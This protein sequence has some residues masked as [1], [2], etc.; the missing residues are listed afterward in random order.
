MS[1]V[2]LLASILAISSSPNLSSPWPFI[3]IR[4][5]D[6]SHA[7]EK[8]DEIIGVNA[9]HPGSAD[10]YWLCYCGGHPIDKTARRFAKHASACEKM[11]KAGIVIGC[12]QGETLGHGNLAAPEGL[13]PDDAWQVDRTGQRMRRLCPRSPAVLTYEADLVEAIL[14]AQNVRSIWLDDDLRMGLGSKPD[15]CYCDRCIA[16]FNEEYGIRL[17]RAELVARLDGPA[18]KEELRAK[19]RLFKNKSLACFGAAAR[20]GADRVDPSV[21]L[22]YQSLDSMDLKPCESY[23]PL[24]EAL[25]GGHGRQS[26]IRA[27]AGTYYE[28]MPR[29]Y[30]KS[31]SVARDAERC[32][33]SPVVAQVSYEQETYTREVLHKSAEAVLIESAMA[34]A[35]GADALTEY[36]WDADR[37]EPASYYEE[38]AEMIV[39]WRPYLEKIAA[40]SRVTSLG[41]L[42]RYR[43]ADYLQ[44]KAHSI[45]S[46]ID[47]EFGTFGVP[48][49]VFDAQ[50]GL[51]YVC[52][53]TLD[54]FG[55]GD[56][57]RIARE[58]AVVD[59]A[60]W[61][62]FLKL[63]PD[64]SR[65]VKFDFLKMMHRTPCS[66]PTHAERAAFLDAVDRI[67]PL[68]VRIDRAHPLHVYPRVAADGRTKAVTLVNASI[69]KCLPTEVRVRK[70]VSS[71]AWWYRPGEKPVEL[72]AVGASGERVV[73][74]PGLPGSQVGTI[75]FE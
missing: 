19:W 2:V 27:G 35:A 43:G 10:E 58:G 66:V 57:E 69:G 75:V 64:V 68:P 28:S 14:K 13:F 7:L 5:V 59:A 21:R 40:I 33:R 36:W 46:E 25:A 62:R 71:G 52:E 6:V 61:D 18:P 74:M 16:A 50:Q 56:A 22:C 12:Q 54:E 24:L 70:P 41:G 34:L 55:P 45:R 9:R 72:P 48:M 4:Q 15:G 49:T 20:R 37:D 31:L 42:A 26:A 3:T 53:K 32:H 65:T 63:V 17:T 51:Y 1:A 29:I 47:L 67:K 38:F 44:A 39:E 30:A 11:K 8:F 23:I 73:R 60:I